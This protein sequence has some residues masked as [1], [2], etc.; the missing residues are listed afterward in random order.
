MIDLTFLIVF[1]VA[2]VCCAYLAGLI[3]GMQ[4]EKET[5]PDGVHEEAE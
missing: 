2:L 5:N 4:I 3:R 1:N